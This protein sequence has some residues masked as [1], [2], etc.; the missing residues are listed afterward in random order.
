MKTITTLATIAIFTT[1]S[2][3]QTTPSSSFDWDSLIS[4]ADTASTSFDLF[5]TDGVLGPGELDTSSR[6]G[7]FTS[8]T[9]TPIVGPIG[10]GTVANGTLA[11]GTALTTGGG[12]SGTTGVVGGGSGGGSVTS[13]GSSGSAGVSVP[14][15][16]GNVAAGAGGLWVEGGGLF[17]VIGALM[18][19]L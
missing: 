18:A 9:P 3:A 8:V 14:A 6:A 4:A 5:T 16:T 12:G 10:N 7:L 19:A 2:T 17:V 13:G 15:A 1:G 11:N